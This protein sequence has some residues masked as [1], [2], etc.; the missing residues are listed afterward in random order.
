MVMNVTLGRYYL[1]WMRKE[2]SLHCPFI[3]KNWQL[4]IASSGQARVPQ[5]GLWRTW[6]YVAIVMLQSRWYLGNLIGRLLLEIATG[7]TILRMGFAPTKTT[8]KYNGNFQHKFCYNLGFYHFKFYRKSSKLIL[9]KRVVKMKLTVGQADS[10]FELAS[11]TV[12]GS[13]CKG[14]FLWI[15]RE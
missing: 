4:H 9:T 12:K 13:C 15:W 5:L 2:R 11:L 14:I 8:G 6:G 7:F 1:I 3:V 10:N